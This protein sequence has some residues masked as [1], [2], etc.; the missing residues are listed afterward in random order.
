MKGE[1]TCAEAAC[2]AGIFGQKYHPQLV[3]RD[4]ILG[5][6]TC[7]GVRLFSGLTDEGLVGLRASGEAPP[8]FPISHTL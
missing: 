8:G 1:C 5:G 4:S 2:R 3:A 7:T 6:C